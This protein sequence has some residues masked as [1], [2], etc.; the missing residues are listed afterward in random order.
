MNKMERLQNVIAQSGLTSRRKAEGLI[1]EGQVKVNGEIVTELGTKVSARDTVTV[2]DIPLV[3]EENVYYLVYKPREV[4][5]SVSDDRGRKVITDLIPEVTERIFPVGRLDYQTS[6]IIL[7]TNDGELANLLM[8]PRYEV[9]KRYVARLKGI[10][11]KEQLEQVLT[12]VQSENDLLKASSYKVLSTDRKRQTMILEITLIEGKNR[13]IR[14]MMEAIGFPVQ[15]LKR[16][17][18]GSLNL[19]Q[20]QPGDSR[21]LTPHEVKELRE[22]ALSE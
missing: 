4:I 19:H 14:R 9:E 10:P 15:K 3:K 16:E 20:L 1:V 13:H 2:N 12:G 7:L 8:H 18:Y 5:T 22:L 6:G 17:T 11:T 21:P